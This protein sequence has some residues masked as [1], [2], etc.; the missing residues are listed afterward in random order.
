MFL[1]SSIINHES[2]G[3]LASLPIQTMP[4]VGILPQ[5]YPI[6]LHLY[7]VGIKDVL[8]K[9]DDKQTPVFF[10]DFP[11]SCITP[12]IYMHAGSNNNGPM[13][14]EIKYKFGTF[15]IRLIGDN[16]SDIE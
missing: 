14:A 3:N 8:V 4:V 12:R 1:S 5:P 9:L 16:G 2:G 13:I 7:T 15:T 6:R 10:F 11:F